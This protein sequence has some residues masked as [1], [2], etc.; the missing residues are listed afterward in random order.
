MR[1]HHEDA[2][3]SAFL[4]DELSDNDALEVTRHLARCELC[5]DD[6]EALRATRKA[7]R[8]LPPVDPP[9]TLWAGIAEAAVVQPGPHRLLLAAAAGVA[10]GLTSYLLGM[11]DGR[12]SLPPASGHVAEAPAS[13]PILTTVDLEP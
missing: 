3:L 12:P 1:S 4:D 9:D 11:S 6:L 8:G 13:E 7:V 10:L 5:L 2:R